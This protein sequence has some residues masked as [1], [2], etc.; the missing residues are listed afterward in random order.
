MPKRRPAVPKK[1][2]KGLACFELS[3]AVH[4]LDQVEK[5]IGRLAALE[6][7]DAA[8]WLTDLRRTVTRFQMAEAAAN[9][10]QQQARRVAMVLWRR[11]LRKW[12][13][14]ELQAATGYND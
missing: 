5:L 6:G 7:F 3:L 14:R 9:L 4:S 13:I 11:C 2:P 12:T 1:L 8:D 10:A